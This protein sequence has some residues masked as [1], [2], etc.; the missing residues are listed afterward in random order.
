M[1]IAPMVPDAV[2]VGPVALRT[3]TLERV[4][5]SRVRHRHEGFDHAT[6]VIS[7][8]VEARHNDVAIGEFGPGESF[9]TPANVDHEVKAIEP[10]M[11]VC[12]FSHRDLE[13]RIVQ[14]YDATTCLPPEVA[15]R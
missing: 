12:V 8:R 5:E 2:I 10:G 15:Y 4:C 6:I 1:Q 14:R 11:F 9:E 13:G 7:G 3:V